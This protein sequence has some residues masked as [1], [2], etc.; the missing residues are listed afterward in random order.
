MSDPCSRSGW[1]FEVDDLAGAIIQNLMKLQLSMK[2]CLDV[3]KDK[4]SFMRPG[5]WTLGSDI[6]SWT[7]FCNMCTSRESYNDLIILVFVAVV[8]TKP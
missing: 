7:K 1:N 3:F 2:Q 8:G 4:I 6:T 5:Y